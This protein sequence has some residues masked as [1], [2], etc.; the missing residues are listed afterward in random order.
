MMFVDDFNKME[1]RIYW[2]VKFHSHRSSSRRGFFG[3]GSSLVS[4]KLY[5]ISFTYSVWHICPLKK[6]RFPLVS[7]W[8]CLPAEEDFCNFKHILWMEIFTYLLTWYW[9][10]ASEENKDW[11]LVSLRVILQQA[12]VYNNTI[13]EKKELIDFYGKLF[14]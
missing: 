13:C 6:L 3:F 14:F 1:Q 12:E 2:K 4:L 11:R 10:P 9:L 5:I 7:H 8:F